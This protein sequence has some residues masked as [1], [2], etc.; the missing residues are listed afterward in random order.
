VRMRTNVGSQTDLVRKDSQL[1]SSTE[2]HKERDKQ[3]AEA[4]RE[5]RQKARK[6]NPAAGKQSRKNR[7]WASE[8]LST[9]VRFRLRLA[10]T[11]A[12]PRHSLLLLAAPQEP[13]DPRLPVPPSVA[14]F[15]A[16]CQ[17]KKKGGVCVRRKRG[18]ERRNK[19]EERSKS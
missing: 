15:A 8:R 9:R 13:C 19:S 17:K 18:V 10:R 6:K 2:V 1:N 7:N 16:S 11:C 14:C 5:K 12:V 3:R 4:Q